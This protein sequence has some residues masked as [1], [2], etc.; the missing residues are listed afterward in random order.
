MNLEI[1][2]KKIRIKGNIDIGISAAVSPYNGNIVYGSN[3]FA[4]ES[5]D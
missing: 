2:V 3:R 1:K 5:S 4:Q